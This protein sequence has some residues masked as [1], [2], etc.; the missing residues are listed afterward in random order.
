[1]SFDY[2]FRF[3]FVL[4]GNKRCLLGRNRTFFDY[5]AM[6]CVAIPNVRTA[7]TNAVFFPSAQMKNKRHKP[8]IPTETHTI[9][10]RTQTA[11]HSIEVATSNS[12]GFQ[13]PILIQTR[14]SLINPAASGE[15]RKR[16]SV[17]RCRRGREG[18][19]NPHYHVSD[20]GSFSLTAPARI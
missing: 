10:A 13:I 7:R 1:M 6:Y 12:T 16:G 9:P 19:A 2:V 8:N 17:E 20:S 3:S 18:F 15:P 14:G 5:H 4:M 11:A